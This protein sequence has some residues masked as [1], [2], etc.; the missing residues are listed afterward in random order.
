MMEL[1]IKSDNIEK[2][3]KL[4]DYW[5]SINNPGQQTIT[6]KDK[7]VLCQN[8]Q[9]DLYS[10][11]D[12]DEVKKIVNYCNIKYKGKTYCRDCQETIGGGSA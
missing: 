12:A 9:R 3:K 11:Y 1:T 5:Q 6:N 4:L 10:L 8:C 2:F 7:K